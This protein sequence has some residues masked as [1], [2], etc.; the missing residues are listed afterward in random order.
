MSLPVRQHPSIPSGRSLG[1]AALLVAVACG[2]DRSAAPGAD[3][4]G[5]PARSVGPSVL[6]ISLD[7]V[8]ADHMALYGGRARCP[9][10]EAL[11]ADAL[12]FERAYSHF[13]ETTLSHWSMLTG[14]LPEVHGNVPAAR[15]SAYT[16]PT[17]AEMAGGV[18]YSTAAFV[19]GVTM[20]DRSTGLSRGFERYDDSVEDDPVHQRRPAAEI[21]AAARSWIDEQDGSWLAF[22]H[23]FDAH[24]PYTPADPAMYDPD[25]RGPVDGTDATL[26]EHRDFGAPLDPQD[27]AHVEALYDAEISE[28]DAALGALLSDLP[29]D[30]VVVVT[31]DHGES[32]G[33]GYL[34]NHRAVLYDSVLHVPLILRAPGVGPA[35]VQ[36]QVGLVDLLPTVATA[37]GLSIPD[38]VQ[39]RSLLQAAPGGGLRLADAVADEPPVWART[40]P[41]LPGALLG[42][43]TPADKVI[44]DSEGRARAFD[45]QRDPGELVAGPVP[46]ALT[47]GPAR[48]RGLVDAMDAHRQERPAGPPHM[49]PAEIERLRALGYL[50]EGPPPTP[51][52]GGPS[53]PGEPRGD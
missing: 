52:A 17:I 10:L 31:S 13:P 42:V 6:W 5:T 51:P 34:F 14:V 46:D 26:H 27:L 16:G 11:A 25:Y 3:A 53:A 12:V 30:T 7:T 48:Y 32:F 23:Y 9:E 18:G 29:P 20:L 50:P 37:A 49:D 38:Q 45:L 19:G 1:L 39:G 24:F 28:L 40:D 36:R 33:H 2:A 47:D 21:S 15:D 22:V 4:P 8:R 35:R 44:W 43:R 41:W